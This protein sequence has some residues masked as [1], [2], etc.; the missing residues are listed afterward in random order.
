MEFVAAPVLSLDASICNWM[1]RSLPEQISCIHLDGDDIRVG[2]WSGNLICWDK[3]GDM[4][5]SFDGP[6]RVSSIAVS[7]NF[8]VACMGLELVAIDNDGR[9]LWSKKLEGSADAVVIGN[10][11]II[12]AISSV[13]DI[14]HGDFM[15]SAYW[16]FN[17]EG[18]EQS[19]QRFDERPWHM[20]LIDGKACLGL[21]RPRCGLLVFSD[22]G[23]G[24]WFELSEDDPV[25]CG[26]YGRSATLF[27]HANG[28]VSRLIKSKVENLIK[29]NDGIKT[30]ICTSEGFAALEEDG[31]L[32]SFNSKAE[33][34]GKQ[35]FPTSSG[36]CDSFSPVSEDGGLWLIN[37]NDVQVLDYHCEN[38]LQLNFPSEVSSIKGSEN[39]AI[40]GTQ[41]GEIYVFEK[42]ML[43]R[44]MKATE[45][46]SNSKQDL[47]D[48]LRNLRNKK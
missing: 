9:Q 4:K 25:S 17:F 13:F 26:V 21:G 43:A 15:E 27:G 1:L 8:Q 14:E 22:E 45:F 32:S 6:D 39:L 30:V 11:G 41:K 23:E 31:N 16:R 12:H 33:E 35:Q 20:S 42:E 2:D 44:R 46:T 7:E 37:G 29:L 24:E 5:W 47:R 48:K 34:K 3:E 28:S 36:V 40:I 10:D 18:E 19:V 38:I